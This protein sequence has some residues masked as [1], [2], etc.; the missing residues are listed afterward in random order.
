MADLGENNNGDEGEIE[1]AHDEMADEE[2]AD[3]EDEQSDI[4]VFI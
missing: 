3:E 1:M 4:K 2:E